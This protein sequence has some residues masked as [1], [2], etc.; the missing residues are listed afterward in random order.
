MRSGDIPAYEVEV[1]GCAN[2]VRYAGALV[3]RSIL[4]TRKL[5]PQD[6]G[7]FGIFGP[8]K[9]SSMDRNQQPGTRCRRMTMN[10]RHQLATTLGTP[11]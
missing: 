7:L 9:R 3:G 2:G 10:R 6:N 5:L 11:S 1:A 8:S 4:G